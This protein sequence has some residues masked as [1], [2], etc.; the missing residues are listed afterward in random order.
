[1][2]DEIKGGGLDGIL[3][4]IEVIAGTEIGCGRE[5]EEKKRN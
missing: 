2:K 1:M 5:E 3:D 4:G